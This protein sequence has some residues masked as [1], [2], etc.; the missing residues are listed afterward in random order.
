MGSKVSI[1]PA[2]IMFLVRVIL[3]IASVMTNTSFLE[4]RYGFGARR[5][6]RFNVQR[7]M[8]IKINGNRHLAA[9]YPIQTYHHLLFLTGLARPGHPLT[10]IQ[11]ANQVAAAKSSPRVKF[12][13][14]LPQPAA[15]DVRVN[16]RC[17]DA[18]V[19]E[20]FLDHAQIRAVPTDRGWRPHA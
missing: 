20:Q 1:K 15:G 5:S 17:A 10:K 19:A 11:E 18:R 16:L 14:N 12:P 2:Q 6:R 13:V 3:K 7:S 8:A 4:Q 9:G